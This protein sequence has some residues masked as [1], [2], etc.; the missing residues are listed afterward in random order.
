MWWRDRPLLAGGLLIGGLVVVFLIVVA[1]ATRSGGP[2]PRGWVSA[3]RGA[4]AVVEVT[5]VIL[6]ASETIEALR[7]HGENPAVR[8]IVLRIDSPGGAVGPAQEIYEEVK[9]LRAKEGK[10]VVAS[11]GTVAASGGY[12]IACAADRIVA[13]PG[14]ITG[15]IG[16]IVQFLNLEGLGEKLGVKAVV[17]K[18][19]QFKDIGSPARP[20]SEEDR[21]IV[22][23]VLDDVHEQFVEAVAQGR[24]LPLAEVRKIADGRIMSGQQAKAVG[25][26]DSFG[27]L[28]TAIHEAAV[29]A[30]ISGEPQVIFPEKPRF[31]IFDLLTGEGL[32]RLE[33]RL[34]G[35]WAPEGLLGR[36]LRLQYLLA[37]P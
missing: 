30:D 25:L 29:L 2:F 11:M 14:T 19:G 16:V 32:A 21:R 20:L 5:G 33:A 9:R 1:L 12:Y 34:A 28:W 3:S 26:V 6:D 27:N 24:G 36:T 8:A 7:K 4:V 17:V 13:N 31:S 35:G 22:Q 23:G 15:S 10:K 37:V 18:S